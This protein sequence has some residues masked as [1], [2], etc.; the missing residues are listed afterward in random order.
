M[1]H[2]ALEHRPHDLVHDAIGGFMGEPDTAANDPIFWLHHCNIDRLWNRW[3]SLGDKRHDPDED[4]TWCQ[5][6]FTFVDSDGQQ[7]T[8]PISRFLS[9]VHGNVLDYEYDDPRASAPPVSTA[10]CA[11]GREQQLAAQRR[12]VAHHPA[13]EE[14][15]TCEVGDVVVS[16][17]VRFDCLKWL[18]KTPFHAAVYKD[19]SPKTKFFAKAKVLFKANSDRLPKDNSRPPRI[20]VSKRPTSAVLTT[21]FFGFDT[22]DNHYGLH[23]LGAVSEMGD[24]VLGMVCWALIAAE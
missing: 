15:A 21:D 18:K 8:L 3:L 23:G 10:A 5:Q 9:Y 13:T 1:N 7:A 16:P 2:G 22:S 17:I 20:T 11:T 24:A 14:S 4:S 6:V 12:V 19:S